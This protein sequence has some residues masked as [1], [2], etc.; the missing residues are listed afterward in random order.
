M[1]ILETRIF[2]KNASFIGSAGICLRDLWFSAMGMG[3]AVSVNVEG[4]ANL[5]P[6]RVSNLIQLP[7]RSYHATQRGPDVTSVVAT[8]R[9]TSLV[10]QPVPLRHHDTNFD[11]WVICTIKQNEFLGALRPIL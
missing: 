1:L 10:E 11:R 4:T 2:P 3:S 9:R 7:S 8:V 6:S 5:S